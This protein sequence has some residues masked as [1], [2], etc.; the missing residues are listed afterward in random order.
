MSTSTTVIRNVC[1]KRK[2]EYSDDPNKS[3]VKKL[4]VGDTMCHID[5]DDLEIIQK[6]SVNILTHKR[7][8]KES[9]HKDD[10]YFQEV[11]K[12]KKACSKTGGFVK[13]SGYHYDRE[14]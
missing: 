9:T 13:G 3:P 2:R 11:R 7:V 10:A 1:G 6:G 14:F 12:Y 4:K 8:R 5:Q